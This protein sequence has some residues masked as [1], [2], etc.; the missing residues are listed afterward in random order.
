M[1]A[2]RTGVRDLKRLKKLV[3]H[4]RLHVRWGHS[5]LGRAGSESGHV[6]C[7]VESGSQFRALATW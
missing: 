1:I 5:R 7:A 4:G 2:D 6:R 3:A